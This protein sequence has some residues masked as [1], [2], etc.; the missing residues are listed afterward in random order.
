MLRSKGVLDRW[1]NEIVRC[2][3]ILENENSSSKEK[4]QAEWKIE[5]VMRL[6]ENSPN[7]L[8]KL[9]EA[10]EKKMFLETFDKI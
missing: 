4:E 3:L 10:V 2:E 1:A 7:N 5:A 9:I 8:A 6:Y